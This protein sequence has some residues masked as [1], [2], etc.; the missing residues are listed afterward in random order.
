MGAVQHM[1]ITTGQGCSY[2]AGLSL[3]S[4]LKEGGK[5]R[6]QLQKQQ[7]RQRISSSTS[8][9]ALWKLEGRRVDPKKS[10]I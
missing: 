10:S 6:S 4:V 7:Q 3:A 5:K 2:I 1:L 9:R 8:P